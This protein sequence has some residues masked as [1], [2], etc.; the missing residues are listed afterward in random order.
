M[1]SYLRKIHSSCV[2]LKTR[3]LLTENMGPVHNGEFEHIQKEN[4]SHENFN[5]TV[6]L[7]ADS[8]L[9]V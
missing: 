7:H 8:H 2:F 3:N 5:N 1:K 6:I 4:S 9:L